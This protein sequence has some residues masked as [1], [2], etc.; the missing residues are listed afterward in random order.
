MATALI[1][2][3]DKRG[4]IP[5]AAGLIELGFDLISTGGTLDVLHQASIPA[6]AASKVTGH[7]EI[8][9]GRGNTIKQSN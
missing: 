9:G 8:L 2:V 5:F 1:S 4:L 6:V 7:S 3:S